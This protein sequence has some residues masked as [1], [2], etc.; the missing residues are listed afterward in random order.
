[1]S[2][3]RPGQGRA[4]AEVANHLPPALSMSWAHI[5]L[6]AN[7]PALDL[8]TGTWLVGQME[9]PI[10]RAKEDKFQCGICNMCRSP[11]RARQTCVA[12]ELL[13]K[14]NA[15]DHFPFGNNFLFCPESLEFAFWMPMAY[16]QWG[17]QKTEG[18][19]VELF[20]W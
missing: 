11:D 9:Q 8:V 10:K 2:S 5:C 7:D 15:V 20:S 4:A 17:R 12:R 1:M 6:S 3:L 18:G 19:G 13:D 16:P 14:T